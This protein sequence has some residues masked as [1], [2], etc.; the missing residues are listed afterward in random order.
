MRE[1][2][3]LIDYEKLE[4]LAAEFKPKLII[5]GASAYPRDYEYERFRQ[6]ADKVGALL[7]CDM[8]HY[9][10]LVATGLLNSP[11]PYCDIVTSTTHKSLRGPRAGIIFSRK[12][13]EEAINFAVFPMC[14]GGPHNTN[15]AALAVQLNEI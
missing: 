10:G 9:S 7:M 6:I 5:C 13:H 1:D 12:K 8:A 15:I 11:F 3:Q 2:T 4:E 14:Q